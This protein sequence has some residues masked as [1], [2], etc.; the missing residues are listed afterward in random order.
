MHEGVIML[1]IT[2]RLIEEGYDMAPEGSQEE[3]MFLEAK[4]EIDAVRAS[5]H[6]PETLKK[7]TR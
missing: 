5:A 1:D 7:E 3:A 2:Y 6:K 4:H